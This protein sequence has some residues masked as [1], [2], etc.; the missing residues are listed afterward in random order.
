MAKQKKLQQKIQKELTAIIEIYTAQK[1]K[2][3]RKQLKT[4]IAQKIAEILLFQEQLS[5][6]RK[7]PPATQ[8]ELIPA[9]NTNISPSPEVLKAIN[10]DEN[11]RTDEHVQP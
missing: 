2:E 8:E 11:E 3:K 4:F 10:G 6:T 9:A 1:G 7:E 5:N